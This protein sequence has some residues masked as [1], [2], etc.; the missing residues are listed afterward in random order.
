MRFFSK[1]IIVISL[2]VM[3]GACEQVF[4]YTPYATEVSNNRQNSHSKNLEVLKNLESNLTPG[5]AFRFSLVSDSHDYFN[6]LNDAISAIARDEESLFVLHGGDLTHHGILKEYNITHDIMSKVGKPWLTVIGNH[7]FVS[8]G[9]IIYEQMF[10]EMNYTFIFNNCKFVFFNNNIWE[11]YNTEP[12][13]FWLE[14]TLADV[15]AYDHTFVVAH[16]PPWGDQFTDLYEKVY[17]NIVKSAGVS[18]SIHGHDHTHSYG[19]NYSD[20]VDY[21]IIGTPFKRSYCTVD[22]FADSIVVK[23]I[24]F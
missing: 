20:E 10:G 5:Q 7:D 18:L 15:R 13:F 17:Q 23:Q 1:K 4:E 19:R 9:K 8:N 21:L 11:N 6:D 2:I 24:P 3:L 16:I 12:D 22:V 14:E